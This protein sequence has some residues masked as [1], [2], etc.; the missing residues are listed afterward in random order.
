VVTGG[1]LSDMPRTEGDAMAEYLSVRGDIQRDRILREEAARD[2]IQNL[3]NVRALILNDMER[4]V[5]SGAADKASTVD[6][7]P[8][9]PPVIILT[10]AGRLDFISRR[11]CIFAG[12][13][14]RTGGGWCIAVPC[15]VVIPI[16][17]SR[18]RRLWKLG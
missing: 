11:S 1:K 3:A 13:G 10:M 7:D 9:L 8:P 14:I 18:S 12:G 5:A 2:T 4:D 15:A 6:R 16:A 17:S